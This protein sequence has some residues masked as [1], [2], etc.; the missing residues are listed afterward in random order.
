[1]PSSLKEEEAG[2]GEGVPERQDDPELLLA[3]GDTEERPPHAPVNEYT[4]QKVLL[5][6]KDA[7]RIMTLLFES[8]GH[9]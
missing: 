2:G 5:C 9:A 6:L 8:T 7:A 3:P 1:M 4:D